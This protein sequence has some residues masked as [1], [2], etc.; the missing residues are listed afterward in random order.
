VKHRLGAKDLLADLVAGRRQGR[1][2]GQLYVA[3]VTD[4]ARGPF[5]LPWFGCSRPY[6]GER[7]VIGARVQGI[8]T[9][10]LHEESA[11]KQ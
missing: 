7:T 3:D 10:N 11:D 6:G 8:S 4:G 2:V 9:L 5:L 1:G